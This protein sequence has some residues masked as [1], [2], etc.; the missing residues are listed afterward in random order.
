MRLKILCF[1]K[2]YSLNQIYNILHTFIAQTFISIFF[3]E[4]LKIPGILFS[5]LYPEFLLPFLSLVIAYLLR[6]KKFSYD[7]NQKNF[8][9]F[10]VKFFGFHLKPQYLFPLLYS[11]RPFN[12]LHCTTTLNEVLFN[13]GILLLML[14]ISSGFIVAGLASIDRTASC[15][16]NFIYHM[17]FRIF[18]ER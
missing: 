10:K 7:M 18:I 2:I 15:T 3:P 13:R 1:D 9:N 5:I 4:F 16:C 14:Q 11:S 17:R 6:L 8:F 12:V